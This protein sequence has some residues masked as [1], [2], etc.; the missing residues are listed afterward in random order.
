M[1]VVIIFCETEQRAEKKAHKSKPFVFLR[2]LFYYRF[3]CCFY[4]FTVESFLVLPTPIFGFANQNLVSPQAA[5]RPIHNSVTEREVLL[6][7]GATL[8]MWPFGFCNFAVVE[9]IS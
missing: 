8:C 9:R 6:R 2:Q 7:M 4:F 3:V 5:Q 1:K